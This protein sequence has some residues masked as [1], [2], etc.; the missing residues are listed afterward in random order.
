[1]RGSP[2]ARALPTAAT[3]SSVLRRA[4]ERAG[5][6]L[7][8]A[9]DRASP[10]VR[11]PSTKSKS[12]RPAPR[13]E[14]GV[15]LAGAGRLRSSP[16]RARATSCSRGA[17]RRLC[18]R[19]PRRRPRTPAR[20][21]FRLPARWNSSAL[22]SSLPSVPPRPQRR[23]RDPQRPPD[24]AVRRAASGA[25]P[26]R[27]TVQGRRRARLSPLRPPATVA[28]Q[29]V[30]LRPFR[31]RSASAARA[32]LPQLRARTFHAQILNQSP[33]AGRRSCSSKCRGT[34]MVSVS[35]VPSSLTTAVV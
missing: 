1:V 29:R 34:E 10:T 27:E 26:T 21:S 25:L 4:L 15:Q 13:S 5:V 6:A 3:Y 20:R 28:G 23:R 30:V 31:T 7:M 18:D 2:G 12:R 33:K 35:R 16:P 9:R 19:S 32:V 11:T 17:E 8:G 24:S 22:R 14:D